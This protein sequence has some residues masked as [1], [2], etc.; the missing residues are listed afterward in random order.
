VDEEI[1]TRAA[2]K[3]HVGPD[4]VADSERRRSFLRRLA[5]EI[6]TVD[7]G[8]ATGGFAPVSSYGGA[9]RE[10]YGV[11]IREAIDETAREG[12]AV[13]V[14]HAASYLLGTRPEV[15][16]VLVTASTKTRELRIAEASGGGE[17]QAAKRIRDDD[18]ARADYLKRF[19]DVEHEAPT[20]YDL[21]LNT[22]RLT[23]EQAVELI[24]TALE[25]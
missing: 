19:Y 24:A 10:D 16:R 15:L 2:E 11:F 12:N 13:I 22:D 14:A 8:A 4:V 18:S 7:L 21:V 6:G 25:R 9:G 1:I 23:T 17:K 20:H 3:A 5:E